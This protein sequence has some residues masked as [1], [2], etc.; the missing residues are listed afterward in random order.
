MVSTVALSEIKI[1]KVLSLRMKQQLNPMAYLTYQK[2]KPASSIDFKSGLLRQQ[3]KGSTILS[4]TIGQKMKK[5]CVGGL[6]YIRR[7][8]DGASCDMGLLTASLL[9]VT[10]YG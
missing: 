7:V 3:G 4:V 5:L 2:K 6:R 1:T 9:M 10:D 8:R